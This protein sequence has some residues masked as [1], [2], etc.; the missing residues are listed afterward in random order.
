MRISAPDENDLLFELL[1]PR[2][3]TVGFKGGIVATSAMTVFRM[4][5]SRSL[6][7]TAEFWAQYVGGGELADHRAESLLL[8]FLYGAIAG[9]IFGSIFAVVD[10]RSPYETETKGLLAGLLYS[11]PFTL[12]GE[13]IMLNHMLGMDLEPDESMIFH[14]SHL[15]YGITLGAWIGSRM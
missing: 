2:S 12:L 3:L 6:P 8:H 13:S 4:P 1:N 9:S 5:I 10:T 14:A 11:I 7:P 15:V